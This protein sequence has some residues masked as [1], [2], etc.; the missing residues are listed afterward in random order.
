VQSNASNLSATA[1]LKQAGGGASIL[2]DVLYLF[3]AVLLTPYFLY[4]RFIKKKQSAP[5]SAKMGH[6]P[7]RAAGRKRVWIHAVS[8]G[9]ATAAET[10][11]KALKKQMPDVDVVVSTTTVTGQEVAQ[12]RYGADS[13]FYYPNDLSISVKR[14]LDRVKPSIIVLM[15]LEVWPN[16]TAEAAARGIPCVVVN[17]RVSPRAGR[18]YQQFW[19]LVGP[20]FNRIHRWLVQTDEYAS[21]LK[22]LGV[23]AEKV[24]IAGNIKYDAIDAT[25]AETERA[26]ARAAVGMPADATV[27]VGGSTHP[28]EEPEL[29]RAY[30]ALRGGSCPFLRLILVPRHPERAGDVAAEIAAAGFACVRRSDIRGKGLDAAIAAIPTDK[31]DSWVLLIDTVGELK[32]MYKAADIAFIGGSLIPHGGQNIM[33]PCGLGVPV[34]HG[35]HMHNFNDAMDILHSVN[36]AVEVTRET[37]QP[38]LEKLL[39]DLPH[40]RQTAAR[41]REAFIKHQGATHRAVEYISSQIQ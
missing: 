29:L 39:R 25:L 1:P 12:K 6:I 13:V 10:L 21:R 28:T 15:E 33:E 35:P 5:F 31:R 17:G 37:L 32:N 27:L 8:V 4:R 3:A 38:Q 40:A 20:S 36:G 18:R 7:D 22:T 41:A 11:I 34:I 9:E 24:E 26:P 14:A 19:F 2:L 16:M 23:P 30:A